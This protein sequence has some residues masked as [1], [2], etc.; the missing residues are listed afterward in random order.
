MATVVEKI[1]RDATK[2]RFLEAETQLPQSSYSKEGI[3]LSIVATAN[4]AKIPP[5]PTVEIRE[6]SLPFQGE[7]L[8]KLWRPRDDSVSVI[9]DYAQF[10][11]FHDYLNGFCE[12]FAPPRH[13]HRRVYFA[14][15][16]RNCEESF[17]L[18]RTGGC[19]AKGPCVCLSAAPSMELSPFQT[20]LLVIRSDG[21]P[22]GSRQ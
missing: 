13:A 3:K 15:E 11:S 20:R 19:F 22:I 16:R 4:Y 17:L 7:V 8:S 2:G 5:V 21:R 12:T 18:Y 10:A 14:G 9:H 1:W 6:H